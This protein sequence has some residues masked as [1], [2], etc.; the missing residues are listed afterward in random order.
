MA[1]TSLLMRRDDDDEMNEADRDDLL[2]H[3]SLAG[4]STYLI[5]RVLQ[6]H[7]YLY[8]KRH[9]RRLRARLGVSSLRDESD[10]SEISDTII[11]SM[12][13]PNQLY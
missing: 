6:R 11:V 5:Q 9:V 1:S 10:L 4:F 2:V 12:V 8:S 7:G 3:Y 13:C